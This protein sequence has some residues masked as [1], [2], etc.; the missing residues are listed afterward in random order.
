VVLP[1]NK[2]KKSFSSQNIFELF[3]GSSDLVK[4]CSK[5]KETKKNDEFIERFDV[6]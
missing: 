1:K 4:S 2:K 5:R 6:A 3:K